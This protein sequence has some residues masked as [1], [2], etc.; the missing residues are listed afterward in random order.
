MKFPEKGLQ[1]PQERETE[2]VR[3]WKPRGQAGVTYNLLGTEPSARDPGRAWQDL[4]SR[5]SQ[6]V[7]DNHLW[8]S[9]KA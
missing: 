9:L 7:K 5:L 2:K 1:A 4:G 6:E 3:G 8:K